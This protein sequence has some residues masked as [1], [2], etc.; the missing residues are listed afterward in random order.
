MTTDVDATGPAIPP[1]S[2]IET[3]NSSSENNDTM[4]KIKKNVNNDNGNAGD[5]GEDNGDGIATISTWTD[6]KISTN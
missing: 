4:E 5:G 3:P 1:P 2:A 6:R